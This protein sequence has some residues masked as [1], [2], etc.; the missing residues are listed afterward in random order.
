[1]EL[2]RISCSFVD[3]WFQL[4]FEEFLAWLWRVWEVQGASQKQYRAVGKNWWPIWAYKTLKCQC[5]KFVGFLSRANEAQNIVPDLHGTYYSARSLNISSSR[6]DQNVTSGEGSWAFFE[7]QVL[8]PFI[9]EGRTCILIVLALKDNEIYF[10]NVG[11][12]SLHYF[13]NHWNV[14]PSVRASIWMSK[15]I[16]DN[17]CLEL[18]PCNKMLLW[19]QLIPSDLSATNARDRLSGEG[20]GKSLLT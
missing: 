19:K 11:N 2:A 9:P 14:Q 18:Y 6:L 15:L 3:W 1:M 20:G 10:P 17:V 8:K 4:L 7:R 13:Q 16:F 5:S 12:N